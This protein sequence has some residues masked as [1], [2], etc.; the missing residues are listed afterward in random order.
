MLKTRGVNSRSPLAGGR[1]GAGRR[2]PKPETPEF[3]DPPRI[4]GF[5]YKTARFHNPSTRGGKRHRARTPEGEM[6]TK[7]APALFRPCPIQAS[8]I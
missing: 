1:G 5:A 4:P 6:F 2:P 7:T 8:P 3:R